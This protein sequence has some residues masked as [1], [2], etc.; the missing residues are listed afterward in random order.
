MNDPCPLVVG[1]FNNCIY[2]TSLLTESTIDA[3]SHVYVIPSSPSGTIRSRFGL[4][5][6]G[7]GWTSLSTQLTCNAPLFSCGV[8][9][10]S[11][12]SSELRGSRS[13]LIRVVDRPLRL[14]RVNDTTE[15][16]VVEV[17]RVNDV[18]ITGFPHISFGIIQM[19][20]IIYTRSLAGEAFLFR[21]TS[22]LGPIH[23]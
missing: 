3:L 1:S 15:E 13:L 22:R 8:P 19:N 16:E 12:F 5:S 14:E 17:L 10:Q 23:H 21:R 2:W 4:N 18:L 6:N 7:S 11:M 9:P 20:I